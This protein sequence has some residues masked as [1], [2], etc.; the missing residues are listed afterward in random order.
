MTNHVGNR[1]GELLAAENRRLRERLEKLERAHAWFVEE[2]EHRMR[3][4]EGGTLRCC[5]GYELPC[6]DEQ[7]THEGDCEW[8]KAKE[9]RI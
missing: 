2:T 6:C 4:D 1:I 7:S 5:C 3:S 9:L 8:V